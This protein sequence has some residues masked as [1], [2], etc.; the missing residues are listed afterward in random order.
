MS[1]TT[2]RNARPEKCGG[3]AGRL[4]ELQRA[5]F[6]V[7][8]GFVVDTTAFDAHTSAIDGELTQ[9]RVLGADVPA[10]V[11][12]SIRAAAEELSD[13]PVAVR[14]SG[15]AEDRADASFAGQYETF[16]DVRGPD[17]ILN[18]VRACWASAFSDH[19][20]AYR[21]TL[22]DPGAL[23]M[24]V[25][26]QRMVPADAAGVAFSADPV[27]GARDVATVSAVRGLGERLVSGDVGGEEWSVNGTAAR[28]RR[29]H[30]DV[31][32]HERALAVA[33][34][35]R[36]VEAH[37]GAPQDIEWAYEGDE[38]RLL[39]ARPMT[40]LPE[41]IEWEADGC[42]V[43][44]FRL[45]EWLGGPVSP[46]G[47]SWLV[48]GLTDRA[49]ALMGKWCY[50]CPLPEPSHVFLH[51]WYFYSLE[52]MNLPP[53]LMLKHFVPMLFF[54]F[55]R[56]A[57]LFPPL[58]HLGIDWWVREW[59]EETLPAYQEAVA[60][61]E[62][63]VDDTPVSELIPL[64][65]ELIDHAAA[66]LGSIVAVAG[67]SAKAEFPL[68]AF[69]KKH[70]EPL[71]NENVLSVARGTSAHQ[72]PDPHAV[73][74]L[75][76]LHPTHG[77]REVDDDAIAAHA[78][79]A[80]ERVH[81]EREAVLARARDGL[82]ASKRK[83]LDKLL[84]EAHRAHALRE[85]QT[86]LFTL[87]W[88]VMR[89]AL[90]RVGAAL[91]ARVTL[92][93]PED[94]YFLDKEELIAALDGDTTPRAAL[95]VARRARWKH[96]RQ[97]TPPLVLGQLP[98]PLAA[99]L[100]AGLDAVR[101]TGAADRDGL[102]GLPASPGRVTGA[103]RVIRDVAELDRL[104]E[105]EILVAPLT[106]PGWTPAFLRAAAVVTDT[107]SL[108]SHASVV[109]REYG[110]PAVVGTGDA[111]ARFADGQLITVDGSAGVIEEA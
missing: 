43:R 91:V 99:G 11:T 69:W 18:A 70:V 54:R 7:P 15:L 65:D 76:W 84:A 32:D 13:S 41:S 30:E 51:G 29:S 111:T 83:K 42:F 3:K 94:V 4:G 79:R 38:L 25:L 78:A 35:A 87:A 107:G 24:A 109:A 16:L 2:L 96:Q 55:R 57:G 14:S 49:H 68:A 74:D 75:D 31:L 46:L 105:G 19:V 62:A 102:H 110:I 8:D 5:G 23:S 20:A 10:E 92:A 72:V 22:A 45:G 106:T 66:Q 85:E 90:A 63:R 61:A 1:G 39:Q 26:V 98:G 67:Y 89:R 50:D 9:A 95:V 56:F 6:S 80:R 81:E 60:A 88:P 28:R 58:A 59:R 52:S 12:R 104:Q 53:W 71:V 77:E 103:A 27:T 47:A 93:R 86:A 97:L 17:A 44:D 64:V 101:T 36:D 40:A 33:Q 34:L 21:A 100:A 37:Y 73:Q 108:A 82:P 48:S